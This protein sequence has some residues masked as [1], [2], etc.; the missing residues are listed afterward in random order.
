MAVEAAWGRG[1]VSRRPLGARRPADLPQHRIASHRIARS[2]D[3]T[4][5]NRDHDASYCPATPWRF[6]WHHHILPS[7]QAPPECPTPSD[8]NFRES[9][10]ISIWRKSRRMRDPHA[11]AV[12][13]N[14]NR[15]PQDRYSRDPRWPA[16]NPSLNRS[17]VRARPSCF[18]ANSAVFDWPKLFNKFMA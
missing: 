4:A 12:A 2:P 1:A 11:G 8:K 14:A 15:S 17:R 18:P 9:S 5:K 10:R 13:V 16:P 7:S 3:V 6:A